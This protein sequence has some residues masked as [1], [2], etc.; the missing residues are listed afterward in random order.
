MADDGYG[1][2]RPISSTGSRVILR[3]EPVGRI[4]M[5]GKSAFPHL[6]LEGGIREVSP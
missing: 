1:S 5:D 3:G 6:P 4:S 2:T